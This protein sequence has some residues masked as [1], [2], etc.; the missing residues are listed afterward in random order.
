MGLQKT[1]IIGLNVKNLPKL[2]PQ[3]IRFQYCGA[4]QP[5]QVPDKL[6]EYDLFFLPT[7]GENFGHVIAEALS[8]GLPV[9]ISD[10][11]PWRDLA[12]KSLG[13]DIPLNEV[14]RFAECIEACAAKSPE[15]YIQ[16]RQS[17]RAWALKNIG[18][19]DAIEQN[20][21]LFFESGFTP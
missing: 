17:I 1:K 11:T 13:W 8:S 3:N 12:E 15:E 14:D 2:L 18:N 16:W 6:A 19:Q 21:R 9:L 10:T 7:L 5:M 20:R 4:L